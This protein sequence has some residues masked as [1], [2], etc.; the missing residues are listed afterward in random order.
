MRKGIKVGAYALSILSATAIA[1]FSAEKAISH[2]LLAYAI[3]IA[4]KSSANND[5]CVDGK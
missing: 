3:K 1:L 2:L 4:P 5:E